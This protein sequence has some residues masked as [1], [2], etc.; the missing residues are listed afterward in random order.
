MTIKVDESHETEEKTD[1][2]MVVTVDSD[3]ANLSETVDVVNNLVQHAQGLLQTRGYSPQE[4]RVALSIEKDVINAGQFAW[5]LLKH[6]VGEDK[7]EGK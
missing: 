1:P 4:I 5:D 3:S 7:P 2:D 6:L